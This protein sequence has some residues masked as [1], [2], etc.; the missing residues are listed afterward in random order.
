MDFEFVQMHNDFEGYV[1]V[2]SKAL[3]KI[4]DGE[5]LGDV[6]GNND[7]LEGLVRIKHNCKCV[8]RKCIAHKGIKA[9]EVALGYRSRKKLGLENDNMGYVN[10]MPTNWFCY[11]WNH[12]QSVIK[13]PFRISFVSLTITTVGAII[14][15]LTLCN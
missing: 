15:I 8:Y 4:Q 14:T 12:Y 3:G 7:A 1:L 13:W 6:A 10:V 5:N 11:L 9:N 2:Y